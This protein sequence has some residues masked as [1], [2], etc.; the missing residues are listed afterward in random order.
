MLEAPV[1]RNGQEKQVVVGAGVPRVNEADP[2]LINRGATDKDAAAHDEALVDE[3]DELVALRVPFALPGNHRSGIAIEGLELGVD[4]ADI[5][6]VGK[7]R[8]LWPELARQPEIVAVEE[9]DQLT[10]GELE[11]VRAGF[12]DTVTTVVP[13]DAH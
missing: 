8:D 13:D 2:P 7:Q 6:F 5:R 12:G 1:K 4:E 10:V 11:G 9:A 3:F